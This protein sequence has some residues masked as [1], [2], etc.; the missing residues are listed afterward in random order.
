MKTMGGCITIRLVCSSGLSSPL[1]FE[2]AGAKGSSSNEISIKIA[3][4]V[5]MNLNS[6]VPVFLSK[7]M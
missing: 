5:F 7:W 3:I 4:H 2:V 6:S 1:M